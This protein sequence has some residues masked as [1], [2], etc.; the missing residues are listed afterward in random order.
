[1]MRNVLAACVALA[2]L[3]GSALAKTYTLGNDPAV[4]TITLPDDWKGDADQGALEALS[5]DETIY[6]S[7]E[8]V[9]AQDLKAAGQE[10][11]RILADHKIVLK[12]D[13]RKVEQVT[14]GG[15][16][17]AAIA[18]DATDADGPTQVHMLALKA[19]ADAEVLVVRWGDA[20]AE[21]EQAA[22]LDAI[23]KSLKPTK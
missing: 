18:W 5:P 12:G 9:D 7:A 23:V 8:I 16:P 22:A 13:S 6:L 14:V 2:A 10:L 15:M 20:D 1:M 4:A 17:G 3:S 21:K 19:K 11:A